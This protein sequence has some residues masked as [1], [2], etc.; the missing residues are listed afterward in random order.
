MAEMWAS[1]IDDA[2]SRYLQSSGKIRRAITLLKMRGSSHDTRVREFS[3]DG[4]GI[5]V[6]MAFGQSIGILGL[7]GGGESVI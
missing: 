7:A 2:P 3:I 6:G 5:H 4:E 1:V